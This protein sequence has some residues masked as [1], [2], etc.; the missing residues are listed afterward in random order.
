[1]SRHVVCHDYRG[2]PN[3]YVYIHMYIRTLCLI[4][5]HYATYNN[6]HVHENV[7]EIINQVFVTFNKHVYDVATCASP[8]LYSL[9]F[10][11]STL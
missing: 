3:A 10:T 11:A 1:M 6:A 5:L 4:S 7:S 2:I 9:S 8:H